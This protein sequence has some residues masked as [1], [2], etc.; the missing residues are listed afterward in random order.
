MESQSA[1][2]EHNPTNME[3]GAP[4]IEP[5]SPS[6]E[7]VLTNVGYVTLDTNH[8]ISIVEICFSRKSNLALFTGNVVLYMQNLNLQAWNLA[9]FV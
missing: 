5:E 6:V 7:H 2:T 8:R 3:T 1:S 9:L 4:C